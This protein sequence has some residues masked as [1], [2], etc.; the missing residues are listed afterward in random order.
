[1]K[2]VKIVLGAMFVIVGIVFFATNIDKIGAPLIIST[3]IGFLI[4]YLLLRSAFKTGYGNANS[5]Q[6][7]SEKS[8]KKSKKRIIIGIIVVGLLCVFSYALVSNIN[9]V[10]QVFDAEKYCDMSVT[11]LKKDLGSPDSTDAYTNKGYRLNIYTYQTD[12]ATIEFIIHGDEIVRVHYL[13]N[14]PVNFNG[15][16]SGLF[17]AFGI[18]PGD[19]VRS[20]ID[21]NVTLEFQSVNSKIGGITAYSI[22]DGASKMIYIT[23]NWNYF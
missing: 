9:P 7:E 23:Y 2:V 21:N 19:S 4:A 14:D 18:E 12:D 13:S 6:K 5:Y 10:D 16:K 1:M 11:A 8:P 20:T 22:E 15:V 3:G 17:S